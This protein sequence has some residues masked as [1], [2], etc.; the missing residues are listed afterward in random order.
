MK[1]GQSLNHLQQQKREAEDAVWVKP[2]P[3]VICDKM[4]KGAYGHTVLDRVVWSCSAT[5]EI[6]VQNLRKVY[7][8]S[9]QGG[10]EPQ[11]QGSPGMLT[12]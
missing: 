5:C 7:Y 4:L 3:C 6:E 1:G 12:D 2:Q 10:N 9:H 8:A 11:A